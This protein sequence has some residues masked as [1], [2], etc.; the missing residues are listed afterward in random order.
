MT[1]TERQ[2]WKVPAK[3]FSQ[4]S[5]ICGERVATVGSAKEAGKIAG[6]A[7]RRNLDSLSV[8][9]QAEWTQRV[10]MIEPPTSGE[11][12]RKFHLKVQFR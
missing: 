3:P 1:N 9:W 4:T 8:M 11:C 7:A 2:D 10:T 6:T 5:T 12:E